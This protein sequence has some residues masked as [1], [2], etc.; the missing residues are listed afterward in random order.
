MSDINIHK[1][2]QLAPSEDRDTFSLPVISR[3]NLRASLTD[4]EELMAAYKLLKALDE[5]NEG[6]ALVVWRDLF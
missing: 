1:V 4:S 3:E 6:E 2:V 5:L